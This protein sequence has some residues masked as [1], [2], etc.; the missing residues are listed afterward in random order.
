[1]PKSNLPMSQTTHPYGY[2]LVNL[3]DWKSRWFAGDKKSYKEYL[4]SD[5]LV[6]A[7]LK[8]KLA[9]KYVSDI[10]FERNQ[11]TTRIMI[12]TSRPGM[13]IG[14]GGEDIKRLRKAL[15][16]FMNKRSLVGADNCQ[17]DIV[18][19]TNPE[20]DA[21]IVAHMVAEALRRRLPFRR[22]LKQTLDKVMQAKG[23]KG[24]RIQ[25][26]GLVGG[27]ASMARREQVKRGPIPLQ[28]IR[29]DIDYAQHDVRGKGVGIKVWINKGDSL[30]NESK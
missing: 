3:R 16:K 21:M 6:R 23:V 8:R 20:G 12:F 22:V 9:S 10:Q 11:K 15:K 25:V 14:R 7:F 26:S 5:I 18:E 4:K 27:S 24:C 29:A 13:V 1:L 30:E 2:R 19:V 28:F 17:L